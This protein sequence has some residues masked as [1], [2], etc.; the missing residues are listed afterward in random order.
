MFATSLIN[1]SH[2]T[3]S[4]NKN[5]TRILHM[6]ERSTPNRRKVIYWFT[7]QL[8]KTKQNQA[9][10]TNKQQTKILICSVH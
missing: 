4:F 1:Y 9:R 10:Q 2:K 6:W 7:N 5:L 3:M 8:S